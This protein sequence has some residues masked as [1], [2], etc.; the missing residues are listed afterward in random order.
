MKALIAVILLLAVTE[1]A[2]GAADL[3]TLTCPDRYGPM[4]FL[5]NLDTHSVVSA[6]DKSF[7]KSRFMFGGVPIS[8]TETELVWIWKTDPR[9]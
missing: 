2:R 4:V 3:A 6:I 8:A 7:G 5:L 1:T 9:I